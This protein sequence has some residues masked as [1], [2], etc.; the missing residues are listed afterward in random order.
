MELGRPL[1]YLRSWH[2]D[3]K[4]G[5]NL[6]C[7]AFGECPKILHNKFAVRGVRRMPENAAQNPPPRNPPK[8]GTK[9]FKTLSVI[10]LELV[11]FS[12]KFSFG[13]MV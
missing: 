8:T 6:P 5:N 2:H 9:V 3:R 4:V 11:F 1:R 7:R 13:F 10:G 12:L